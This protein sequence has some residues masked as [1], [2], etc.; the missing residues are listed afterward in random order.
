M[1]HD[2]WVQEVDSKAFLFSFFSF[3]NF[4]YLFVVFGC[5]GAIPARAFSS[6]HESG[7]TLQSGVGAPSCLGA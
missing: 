7:A 5:A 1:A 4:I 3:F 2:P 6:L